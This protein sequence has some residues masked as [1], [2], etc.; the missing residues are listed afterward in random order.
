MVENPRIAILDEY[1][2]STYISDQPVS[3]QD[4]PIHYIA[5]GNFDPVCSLDHILWFLLHA[6]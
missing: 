4:G 2:V 1:S 3:L 6:G 5:T